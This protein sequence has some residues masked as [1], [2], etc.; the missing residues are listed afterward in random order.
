MKCLRLFLTAELEGI[1]V[2]DI[3]NIL[4]KEEAMSRLKYGLEFM[5]TYEKG[6]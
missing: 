4:G 1:P 6:K 2:K 5:K 3:V